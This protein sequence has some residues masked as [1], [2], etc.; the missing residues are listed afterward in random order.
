MSVLEREDV[1]RRVSD[2][3]KAAVAADAGAPKAR[4]SVVADAAPPEVVPP[5][6]SRADASSVVDDADDVWVVAPVAPDPVAERSLLGRTTP[7]RLESPTL[8]RP[9]RS[10]ERVAVAVTLLAV[11]GV[12]VWAALASRNTRD[13]TAGASAADAPTLHGTFTVWR[14]GAPRDPCGE[15]RFDR[16][17]FEGDSVRLRGATGGRLVLSRLEPG[18]R[19]AAG[20]GCAY[21]FTLQNIPPADRYFVRVGDQGSLVFTRAQ[22]ASVHWQVSMSLGSPTG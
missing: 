5:A 18:S 21:P 8:S 11:A 7:A 1:A 20:R 13:G 22:L 2:A 6:V 15:A 3:L 16:T 17:P 4:I 9:K 19:T 14:G 12:G 10:L